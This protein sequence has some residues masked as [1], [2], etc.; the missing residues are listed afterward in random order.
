M[1]SNTASK[2]TKARCGREAHA[3]RRLQFD[4][5][6]T[7][8]VALAI[9]DRSDRAGRVPHWLMPAEERS[10]MEGRRCGR[11]MLARP[12][13]YVPESPGRCGDGGRIPR[14]T[15]D[16]SCGSLSR[17]AREALMRSTDRAIRQ[18]VPPLARPIGQ[19]ACRFSRR[20]PAPAA[21]PR[22]YARGPVRRL[23]CY[24]RRP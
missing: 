10:I 22:G 23:Y 20:P 15:T 16:A 8:V 21:R 17:R 7:I 13:E 18:C 24:P 9:V 6:F 12:S 1:L 5:Q 11:P 19:G 14:T 2:V 4:A 3:R